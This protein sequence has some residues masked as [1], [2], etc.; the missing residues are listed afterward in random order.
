MRIGSFII[1]VGIMVLLFSYANFNY[2]IPTDVT[3]NNLKIISADPFS[4]SENLPTIFPYANPTNISVELEYTTGTTQPVLKNEMISLKI[5]DLNN[6][7]TSILY[8]NVSTSIIIDN[9]AYVI[10]LKASTQFQGFDKT[11][12]AFSWNV[13]LTYNVSSVVY[14]VYL[15][16]ITFYGKFESVSVL[17]VG[18]FLIHSY[19]ENWNNTT[20]WTKITTTPLFMNS[21]EYVIVYSMSSNVNFKNA[22]I[23][24]NDHLYTFKQFSALKYYVI[25]NI[26]T[27]SNVTLYL[28]STN[29]SPQIYETTLFNVIPSP[30][31]YTGIYI[32]I[33]IIVVGAIV[34][35][36]RRIVE[37]F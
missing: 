11:E 25:I 27:T 14:Y 16:N 26:T 24:I 32:G 21:G 22:Y 9:N 5:E 28:Q 35:L 19:V 3:N 13:D 15:K 20:G 17:N 30:H 34:L 1:I 8:P 18:E 12:Y 10:M 2:Q 7:K 6:S 4:S 33:G 29:S 37:M 23:E 31:N 36:R